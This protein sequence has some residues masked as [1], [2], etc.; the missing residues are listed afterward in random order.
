M[1]TKSLI[2][3]KDHIESFS[4]ICMHVNDND[5]QI[6]AFWMD[7]FFT[8]DLSNQSQASIKDCFL[9]KEIGIE[10]KT[11]MD[12]KIMH[13]LNIIA[14]NRDSMVPYCHMENT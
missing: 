5:S 9:Q 2:S 13:D 6:K 1:S 4:R 12:K 11:C 7:M 8:E 14:G 3:G 10:I